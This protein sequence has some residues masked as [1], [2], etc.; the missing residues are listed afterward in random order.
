[1]HIAGS[2]VSAGAATSFRGAKCLRK[3]PMQKRTA[4]AMCIF[5]E[6][7]LVQVVKVRIHDGSAEAEWSA[8]QSMF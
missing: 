8:S 6:V 5:T 1:M 7:D 2:H 4:K 3:A